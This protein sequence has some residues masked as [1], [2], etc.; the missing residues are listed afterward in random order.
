[1]VRHAFHVLTGGKVETRLIAFSDDMDG[2]RKV[3]GNV[4]NQA[5]LEEHL[6]KPLTVVPNPLRAV[7]RASPITTTPSC[8]RFLMALDLT[9][10][11]PRPPT[12]TGPASSM[13]C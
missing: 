4:P 6:G 2:M 10:S 1:M 5:M 11:S 7:N 12:I 9:M 8:A 13:T 3:P